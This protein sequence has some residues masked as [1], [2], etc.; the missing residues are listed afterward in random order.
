MRACA[1]VL[2]MAKE[3]DNNVHVEQRVNVVVAAIAR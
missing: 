1:Y 3:V 2:Q